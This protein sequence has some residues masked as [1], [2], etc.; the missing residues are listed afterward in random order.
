MPALI[1]C[2]YRLPP[3]HVNA[4]RVKRPS[5]VL[6]TTCMD[7]WLIGARRQTHVRCCYH[8]PPRHVKVARVKRPLGVPNTRV[9]GTLLQVTLCVL[10]AICYND[11]TLVNIRQASGTRSL[12]LPSVSQ[13]CHV[14]VAR[15]KRTYYVPNTT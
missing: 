9:R 5:C 15:V 7:L 6:K 1:R 4:A 8:L 13:P 2:C 14:N 12:L 3:R 11:G 10:H